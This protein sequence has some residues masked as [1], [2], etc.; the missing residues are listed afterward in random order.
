MKNI[1]VLIADD[2]AV[3]RMG[4]SAMLEIEDDIKVVGL[5]KN[6]VE[7]VAETVRLKPD[8]VVMDLMMPQ[9]DGV[10]AT[11]EIHERQSSTKV[12]ILTTF[13]TSDGIAHALE[14]GASGA[15]LK[16]AEDT[17][18]VAAIRKVAAGERYLSSDIRRQLASDPPV[19][20]LTPR[21]SE[22]LR[23]M[24]QGLT[25]KDIAKQLGIRPDGVNL[26]IIDILDK[27]GAANRTE[28]VAIALRKHLLK[29]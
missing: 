28:A 19:P 6:G 3:V 27:L 13:G 26:H 5:A 23:S 24:V 21:Q 17:E 10:E 1:S 14:N 20:Q 25:N 15:V 2:H 11:A 22:I 8:V 4:L 9:K 18:L 12:V 7:A 29:I 16:S